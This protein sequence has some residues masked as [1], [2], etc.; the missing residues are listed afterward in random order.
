MMK[1][2]SIA[3]GSI[4]GIQLRIHI[5]FL[6]LLLFIWFT[7]TVTAGVDGAVRG[8]ALAAIVF[9]SV[10]AHELGHAILAVRSGLKV[11]SVVLLPIGGVTLME[12]PSQADSN[13]QREMRV[14]AIGPIIN[15]LLGLVSGV[16]I[17]VFL[18]QARLFERPYI[19]SNNLVRSFVWANLFLGAFNLLPAYPLDGGRVLRAWFAERMDQVTATRRAVSIGQSFAMLMI[20]AGAVWN[21][22]FMLIGIFLFFGGMLE[23]R[24]AIFQAV[25]ENVHME[26]VM[27]TEFSTLSPA[28]TLE[29]ALEKSLHSLQDDFPVVR[30]TDMVGVIS[31]QAI[32]ENLRREGNGYV[33][34][35]MNRIF[36]VA[37]RKETLA[38]ALT[39]VGRAGISLIPVVDGES[40]VGIV[41]MQNLMH[42]MALLSESRKLR[43]AAEQ[44]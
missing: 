5:G 3:A 9:G 1:N 17:A 12:N 23:D 37:G 43:R 28:D 30:G 13:P 16:L 34:A 21:A 32:M 11:R 8:L 35:A 38:S 33:Q 7:D 42:S 14:A 15:L 10:V 39:K 29:H 20:F 27:L 44:D 41:T 36:H 31:R 4:F 19:I 2:W 24:S 22:W 26:D 40:L 18:P 25:T 6:F